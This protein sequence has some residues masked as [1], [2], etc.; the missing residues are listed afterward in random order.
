MENNKAEGK[1]PRQGV[2]I[3]RHN[4]EGIKVGKHGF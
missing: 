3:L 4:V 1:L 2:Q